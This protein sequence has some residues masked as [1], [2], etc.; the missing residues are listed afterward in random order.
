MCI[1]L[2]FEGFL[3]IF[4]NIKIYTNLK[5]NTSILV[6]KKKDNINIVSGG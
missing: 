5:L 1:F 3:V 2:L 6:N 4:D